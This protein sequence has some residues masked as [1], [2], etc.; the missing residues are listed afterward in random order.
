[1]R[2]KDSICFQKQPNVYFKLI[3][4]RKNRGVHKLRL[5]TNKLCCFEKVLS[6]LLVV[7]T[8]QKGLP[9]EEFSRATVVI[10]P[11]TT[12]K[13]ILR[14]QGCLP[15]REDEFRQHCAITARPSNE[16]VLSDVQQ[17]ENRHYGV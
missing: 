4:L 7:T 12:Y 1:M 17:N 2:R 11:I 3:N 16:M 5:P 10:T 15:L 6:C 13:Q 9:H 8:L 14:Q